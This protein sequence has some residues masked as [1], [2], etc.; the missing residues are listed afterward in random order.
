MYIVDKTYFIKELSVPNTEEH[1]SEQSIQLETSIDRY[2][3]QLLRNV[4]GNVLFTEFNS[5]VTDGVLNVGAPSKWQNLVNGYT[6]TV[7]GVDKV[8]RGLIYTEGLFKGSILADYVYLNHYQSEINTQ[9][10]QI[11][12]EP[13]NGINVNETQHLTGIWNE[14]VKKYQ[15]STCANPIQYYNN[16]SLFVDYYGFNNNGFVSLLEFL[17]DNKS[18]YEGFT[19]TQI[20]FKNQFGL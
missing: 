9:L 17:T 1:N 20:A 2:A 10:G 16:G 6:Y 8:W 18:D 5:N 14:F 19:A 4:L 13:K 12:L 11:V 7:N 3:R 15:G